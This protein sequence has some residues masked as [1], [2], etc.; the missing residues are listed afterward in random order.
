MFC[1]KIKFHD[2]PEGDLRYITISL[3][4][5][6]RCDNYD[7]DYDNDDDNYDDCY[8]DDYDDDNVDASASYRLGRRTFH[9]ETDRRCDYY[10]HYLCHCY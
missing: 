8:D 9:L 3:R 6:L 1:C 10:Y 4:H 7:V 2:L 5:A